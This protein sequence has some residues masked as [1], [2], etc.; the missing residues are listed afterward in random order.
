MELLFLALSLNAKLLQ[1]VLDSLLCVRLRQL[2]VL[3]ELLSLGFVV[4]VDCVR[5]L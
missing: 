3:M 4:V 2:M 1:L 5:S